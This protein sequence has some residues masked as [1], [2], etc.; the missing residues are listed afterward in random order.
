MNLIKYIID[1]GISEHTSVVNNKH[2]RFTNSVSLILCFF[3]I[4]NEAISIYYKEL[5]LC[6]IYGVHLIF[7]ATTL[8]SNHFGK[9][10]FASA[11]L[12]CV[13]IFFV[14][15]YSI[16]YPI[17]THTTVFLSTIIFLQFFLFPASDRKFIY[18]FVG[19]TFL[20]LTGA[21][22][23]NSHAIQPLLNIEQGAI[24]AQRWIV[25]IGMPALSFTFGLYAFFTITR[26]E[27]EAIQEKEKAEQLLLNILPVEVTK[28]LKE[29]GVVKPARFDEVTILFSDFKEF[30]NIVATIP[31]NKLIAEL[32]EI[33]S[34]FDDIMEDE[35]VEKIQTIGDAYLAA[36]GLP[37]QVPDHALRCTRAAKRMIGFLDDRNKENALKWKIRIGMHSGPIAAGVVGK[38]KFAYNIFGD[39]IN[40][41]S[42]VETAGEEGRINVSAYTY[43]LI[44]NQ[45][46]GEYRGKI[47]A[48]GKG[49]LD[50]YFI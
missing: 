30:T 5:V 19:I 7:L 41:A 28:E 46:P 22:L 4:L 14:T 42:R 17:N 45:Y 43:D 23:W 9:R 48:K 20:C 24:E 26:A 36:C 35:G 3:V 49:D 27:N 47:H 34:Q 39:T 10:L 15:L 1:Q 13:M 12:S 33:F 6:I 18:F 25:I 32:D 37:K 21:L 38:K 8:F 44:K 16:L 31:S 11:W 29:Y 2:T 40:T 50:M